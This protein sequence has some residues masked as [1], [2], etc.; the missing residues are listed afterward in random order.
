MAA[1]FETPTYL[2]FMIISSLCDLTD[3]NSFVKWCKNQSCKD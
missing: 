1:P 2:Q 3:W